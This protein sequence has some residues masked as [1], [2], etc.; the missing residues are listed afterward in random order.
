MNAAKVIE[1]VALWAK[2]YPAW[3]RANKVRAS[4]LA[5]AALLLGILL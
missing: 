5:G 2:G 1:A 4:V 3:Y